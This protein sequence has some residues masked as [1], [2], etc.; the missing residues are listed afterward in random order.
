M[1]QKR[2]RAPLARRRTVAGSANNFEHCQDRKCGWRDGC[3]R[4]NYWRP[5]ES[6]SFISS[7]SSRAIS[8]P[9]LL[10]Y[11]PP[12]PPIFL[13]SAHFVLARPLPLSRDFSLSLSISLYISLARARAEFCAEL[14]TIIIIALL[15]IISATL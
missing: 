11:P 13:A 7:L 1:F 14:P 6:V 5:F 2:T 4:D 9:H 15:L 3:R 12:P 10:F 8:L